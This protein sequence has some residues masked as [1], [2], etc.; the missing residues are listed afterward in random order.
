MHEPVYISKKRYNI[1]EIGGDRSHAR[2]LYRSAIQ[3]DRSIESGKS[4][5]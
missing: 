4:K 1:F 3:T 5:Q 2:L